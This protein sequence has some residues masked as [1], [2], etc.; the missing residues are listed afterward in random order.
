MRINDVNK[1]LSSKTAYQK[2]MEIRFNN[3]EKSILDIRVAINN[4]FESHEFGGHYYYY[5][6]SC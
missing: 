3:K 1:I 4:Y 2:I 6:Y 5:S